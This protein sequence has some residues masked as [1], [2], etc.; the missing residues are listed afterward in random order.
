MANKIVK[1]MFNMSY[2]KLSVESGSFRGESKI[3]RIEDNK[4]KMII[5]VSQYL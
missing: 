2:T 4:I 1:V 3:N 5:Q